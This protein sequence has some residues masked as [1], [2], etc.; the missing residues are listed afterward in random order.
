MVRL[1]YGFNDRYLLTVSG[2]WDGASQLAEGHKWDFFPSAAIGWRIQEEE[3]MR[4]IQWIDNLKFRVGVGTTGNAGVSPYTTKGDITS[5]FVP[6]MGGVN[7]PA[8]TTNEPYYVDMGKN[9]VSMANPLLG[10]EKTTQWN[11]GLDFSVLNN[12]I[13][14]QIDF[15]TSKT[16]DLLMSMSIPSL[17]GFSS[18]MANVGQT[19]NKGI[20]VS[21]NAL[22]VQ[23]TNGFI[24]ETNLN[25]AY[26]KDKIEELAYGKNDMTDNSWFIGKQLSVFY[27]Y[28]A[29]G[30]WQDTP[31]DHAEMAKWNENGYKF[32]PGNVRMQDMN[33]D[34]KLDPNDDRVILGNKNPNWTMGWS[35]TFIYKGIE[36]GCQIIGR[37]G[38][39]FNTG[40]EALSATANQ[41]EVDYWTPENTG[42]SY[43]KPILS[44][45]AGG[46][47]DTYSSYLGYQKASFLKMRNISLGYNVPKNVCK[48]FSL[49]NLKI[50]AQCINPFSIHDSVEGFDLDTGKTYFNRSF[51]F[52]LEIGF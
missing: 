36:L 38:Y 50:Y 17:T 13:S 34:Y 24:W 11:I 19:S 41:R 8:Y 23:L 22:P 51:S 6:G 27:G 31:E 25:M 35:N 2:R 40:G 10:W 18:T 49:Q 48:R 4:D 46:S 29:I 5:I 15:Y 26:Q 3:F 12:R 52:G 44:M 45:A 32:E 9:G 28:K 16:K 33:G 37:L 42:A 14:G 47:A 7:I 20:E 43:Q 30:L 21:I 39:T 1:N